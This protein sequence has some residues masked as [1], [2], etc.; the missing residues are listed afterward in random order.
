MP[1]PRAQSLEID[2]RTRTRVVLVAP[3]LRQLIGGQEVQANVLF[4]NWQ[5]DPA[6]YVSFVAKNAELPFGIERIPYL[7][8]LLHFPIYLVT[9]ALRM[10]NADIAHIFSGAGSSFLISTFPAYGVA[11]MFGTKTVIHYHSPFLESHLRESHLARTVLKN[12]SCTAVPSAYLQGVL[13]NF[14]IPAKVIPNVM[15]LQRPRDSKSRPAEQFLLCTRN[16]ESRYGIDIVLRAFAQVQREFPDAQLCLVGTG[17]EEGSLRRLIAELNLHRVEMRGRVVHDEIVLLYQRNGLFVN[18]SRADNM[19]VSIMEAFASGMPV[20][21]TNAGGIS[22]MVEHEQTGLLCDTEDWRSLAANIIRLLRDT[23]L[24]ARLAE[25][26]YRQSESYTWRAV[27]DQWLNLY[28]DV[29]SPHVLQTVKR[30]NL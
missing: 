14:Q 1:E 3:S 9:L 7:R 4:G 27:R 8:T 13:H 24:A 25:N 19:P 23:S 10:S 5:N 29:L 15:D 30:L 6:V 11:K 22:L 21:S 20:I 26:A 18:A 17:P 2:D 12:A 28:R 16:L